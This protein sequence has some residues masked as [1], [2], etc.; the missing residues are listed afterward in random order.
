MV[1]YIAHSTGLWKY[2]NSSEK[3]MC[4]VIQWQFTSIWCI[5]ILQSVKTWDFFTSK[6]A[7]LPA[8]WLSMLTTVALEKCIPFSTFW[9]IS[10][11][12]KGR[13]RKQLELAF[14]RDLIRNFDDL[15]RQELKVGFRINW[16]KCK[17]KTIK[18]TILYVL[19]RY[20]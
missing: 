3:K 9:P 19:S 1:L 8:T 15:L 4:Q 2:T 5:R 13:T 18:E 10:F 14:K 16:I 6:L 12:K 17:N 20:D 11:F 7:N